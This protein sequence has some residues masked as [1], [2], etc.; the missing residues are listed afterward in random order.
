MVGPSLTFSSLL[1][2]ICNTQGRIITLELNLA[3]EEDSACALLCFAGIV[4]GTNLY[5]FYVTDNFVTL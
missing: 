1:V 3:R 5:L 2:I 4:L